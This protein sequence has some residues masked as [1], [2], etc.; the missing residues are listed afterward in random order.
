MFLALLTGGLLNRTWYLLEGST[1][2]YLE[3]GLLQRN[4]SWRLLYELLAHGK[5]SLS[6]QLNQL[7]Q[8]SNDS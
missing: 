7:T 8:V 2:V 3:D 6:A 4:D 5:D 1:V